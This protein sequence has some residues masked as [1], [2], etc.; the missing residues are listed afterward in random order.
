[1]TFVVC[2]NEAM[3]ASQP[4][5]TQTM[6]FDLNAATPVTVNLNDLILSD[7]NGRTGL[8]FKMAGAANTDAPLCDTIKYDP[9][10]DLVAT[11]PWTGN[12]AIPAS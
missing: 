3:D 11:T 2:N 9:F 8:N 5:G 1:M 10:S 12:A 4:P 6:I 7:A